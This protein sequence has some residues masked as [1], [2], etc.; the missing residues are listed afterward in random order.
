MLLGLDKHK[1]FIYIT[2]LIIGAIL[3]GFSFVFNGTGIWGDVFLGLGCGAV[4]SVLTGLFVDLANAKTAKQKHVNLRISLLCGLPHGVMWI[5]KIIIE[6][7]GGV[8]CESS[9]SCIDAFRKAVCNMQNAPFDGLN[10]LEQKERREAILD[11]L[12]YGI[13]LCLRY[14]QEIIKNK[15]GLESDGIF[16][17]KEL[18]GI[19]YLFE[20][21]NLIKEYYLISEMGECIELLIENTYQCLP[22]IKTFFDRKIVFQK[23]RIK[24]WSDISF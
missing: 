21:C 1:W 7:F 13:S 17:D 23:N 18:L 20:Q 19:Q 4:P 11:R 16:S 2:C 24:N 10:P 5:S 8:A 15:Y 22:D 9:N 3:I 14:S 12:S 6:E